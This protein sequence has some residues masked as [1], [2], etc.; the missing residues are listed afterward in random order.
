MTTK[1]TREKDLVERLVQR[2]GFTVA[3]YEDPNAS[4]H[5][6]VVDVAILCVGRRIGV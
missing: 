3:D 6:T 1:F 5:E 2:L 4:G